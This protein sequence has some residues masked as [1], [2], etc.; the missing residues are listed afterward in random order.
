MLSPRVGK[1]TLV[2]GCDVFENNPSMKANLNQSYRRFPNKNM[3]KLCCSLR[4]RR[5]SHR[6]HGFVG[7]LQEN[8]REILRLS[9][10]F[11]RA[12]R[13]EEQQFS[14]KHPQK[15]QGKFS[16]QKLAPWRSLK[17]QQNYSR[18]PQSQKTFATLRASWSFR[19]V[20]GFF[21]LSKISSSFGIDVFPKRG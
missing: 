14:P 4:I 3:A 9:I 17:T 13:S 10:A 6:N 15:H 11:P 12:R 7:G 19:L 8:T 20:G 2:A 21:G 18:K 16:K 5:K 1:K